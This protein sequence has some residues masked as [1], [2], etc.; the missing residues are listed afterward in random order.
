MS[1]VRSEV[2]LDYGLPRLGLGQY[3]FSQPELS[4]NLG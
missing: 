2:H 3:S 4:H 1:H